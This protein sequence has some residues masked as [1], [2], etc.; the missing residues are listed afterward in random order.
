MTL[1]QLF[2]IRKDLK[3][4]E[5]RQKS[6]DPM[7]KSTKISRQGKVKIKVTSDALH[8]MNLGITVMSAKTDQKTIRNLLQI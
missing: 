8:A 6:K 1:K 4:A 2:L 7:L 3:N 5:M